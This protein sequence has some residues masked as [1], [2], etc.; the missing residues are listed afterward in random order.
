MKQF[1]RFL[2]RKSLA[3]DSLVGTRHAVFGLGDSGKSSATRLQGSANLHLQA[4]N[5]MLRCMDKA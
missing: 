4:A 5:L 2:L 3:H 1:W